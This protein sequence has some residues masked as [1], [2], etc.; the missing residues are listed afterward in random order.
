M[1]KILSVSYDQALL[2]TRQ[3][4]LKKWGHSVTS[5]TDLEVRRSCAAAAVCS[6][7]P[8]STTAFQHGRA[9]SILQG[10]EA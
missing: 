6:I 7:C 5:A 3:Q 4:I 8:L 1:A 10:A 2:T 9:D